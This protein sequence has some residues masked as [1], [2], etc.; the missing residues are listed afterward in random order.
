MFIKTKRLEKWQRI[1]IDGFFSRSDFFVYEVRGAEELL[2]SPMIRSATIGKGLFVFRLVL[3][4]WEGV[5]SRTHLV[6]IAFA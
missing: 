5:S 3:G 4:N 6:L 2:S 1:K